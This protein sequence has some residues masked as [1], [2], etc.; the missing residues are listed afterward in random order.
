MFRNFF[1]WKFGNKHLKLRWEMIIWHKIGYWVLSTWLNSFSHGYRKIKVAYLRNDNWLWFLTALLVHFGFY[2]SRLTPWIDMKFWL[3]QWISPWPWI[4]FC[5]WHP[6]LS[7]VRLFW[8]VSFKHWL[9]RCSGCSVGWEGRFNSCSGDTARLGSKFGGCF[10][11]E[12]WFNSCSSETAGLGNKFGRCFGSGLSNDN[13][14]KFS[15][16]TTENYMIVLGH[17]EHWKWLYEALKL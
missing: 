6:R 15:L 9:R 17:E 16:L 1:S 7:W 8:F 12:G 14:Q 2:Y 3:L 5:C 10:G 11:I 13:S 4:C